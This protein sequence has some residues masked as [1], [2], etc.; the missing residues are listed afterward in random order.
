MVKRKEYLEQLIGWKDEQV[1]KVVTGI[2][3]C[4]KSTLLAQYQEWLKENGVAEEQ[5][6]SVNFEELEYEDLL[7]YKRLYQYLKEHLADEKMTYIFL[8]EIQKVP[9][10]EKAVDSL[11]VKPN[12]DLYITG[13]NAYLLSG[14]L[15]TLLTG[16][17]VEIKMLPLS[18]REYLTMTGLEPEQGFPEYLRNGGMP[19]IAAMNRTDEKVSTYLEGIYNTVIVKDIED[20]QARKESEPSKRKITDIAL[21]KTIAKYLASVVGNPVSVRSIT[22]YLISNGRK[23]SP[24]TVGDYVEALTES[25]IFY[26]TERFDIV[27]KQL[28]KANRKMYIVD[29][30]LRNHILPRKS[31]D[32]GFSLENMVYFELLRRGY[33]VTIGKVG[34][35]EVD[36]VAQKQGVYQYFQVTADMTAKETF[37]REIRP[38]ENIRD[39]YEKIILTMERLTPGNYNGIKVWY[40]PDWLIGTNRFMR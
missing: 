31:Y 34:N 12:V 40:L 11:Y 10:F 3:R 29:L 25:F 13:S 39:N 2:R 32:L 30:G 8:D 1:I 35:T 33:Q 7:D 16:R 18:F 15:A 9:F 6:L 36:F 38:L 17:Y 22:D 23:I 20:R 27:G 4:G 21:L 37:D 5:I 26:P 19:Y 14:D 24:N 28:L